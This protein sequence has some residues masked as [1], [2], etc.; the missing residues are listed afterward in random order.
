MQGNKFNFFL[1]LLIFIG[2]QSANQWSEFPIGNTYTE[3]IASTIILLFGY[4]LI[5]KQNIQKDKKNYIPVALFLCWA[6]IGA[7]RGADVAEN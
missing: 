6:V 4:R 3:W 7:I 2:L 5:T 1:W